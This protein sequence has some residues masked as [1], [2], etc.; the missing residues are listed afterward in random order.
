MNAFLKQNADNLWLPEI[1]PCAFS[2]ETQEQ[3][4]EFVPVLMQSFVALKVT[5]P[6]SYSSATD[7]DLISP[8]D[9]NFLPS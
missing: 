8:T 1:L 6:S 9:K 2:F 4:Y 3:K 5:H 7:Q